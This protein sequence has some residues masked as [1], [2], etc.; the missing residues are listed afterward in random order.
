MSSPCK[1]LFIAFDSAEMDLLLRWAE[2]GDLPNL[3]RL[4]EGGAWGRTQTPLG[5]GSD[6]TWFTLLSGVNP[7]HHGRYFALQVF[8]GS[9]EHRK[10]T[11]DDVTRDPFWMELSREGKRVGIMDIPYAPFRGEVNGIM[12]ADWMT[13]ATLHDKPRSWPPALID[14]LIAEFGSDP[15]GNCD[16]FT[17]KGDRCAELQS[18]MLKRVETKIAAICKLLDQGGWDLF[19]SSFSDSHC[20]GHQS[21]HLHDSGHP[22]HDAAW[23]KRNGDPVREVYRA[24]DSA[25]GQL[26]ERAGP[27]TYVVFLAGPGMQANYGGNYLLDQVLRHLQTGPAMPGSTKVDGLQ[28][29]WRRLP[30]GL[31]RMARPLSRSFLTSERSKRKCFAVPHNEIT[32]AIRVNLVGRE[33]HGLIQPGAEYDDFCRELA[34]DLMELVNLDSGQ[35][36]VRDVIRT[37]ELFEGEYMD[38]LPDLLVVWNCERPIRRLGSPKLKEISQA[39]PGVRTGDHSRHMLFVVRG[40]GI[41]QG[42]IVD[43]MDIRDLMPTMAAYLGTSLADI[44][45]KA[46]ESLL[47]EPATADPAE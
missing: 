34:D 42:E 25:L 6:S 22:A 12:V 27:D 39:Y 47:P 16:F 30:M 41:R 40:P 24:L 43:R 33:S 32:G 46:A 17:S 2:A 18:L 1:V 13:H 9:Y 36:A 15:I 11:N 14:D 3:Q 38:L 8:P 31:R 45:G 23:A 7:G 26:L 21:W 20:V 35:P 44:E 29:V 4:R 28:K 19:M 37:H 10:F 5:F